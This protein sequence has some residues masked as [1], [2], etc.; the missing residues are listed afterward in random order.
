MTISTNQSISAHA[1]VEV[2]ANQVKNSDDAKAHCQNKGMALCSYEEICPNGENTVP[3]GGYVTGTYNYGHYSYHAGKGG[4]YGKIQAIAVEGDT[5]TGF[6][7]VGEGVAVE[8]R[9]MDPCKK[10][11]NE[12]CAPGF[13][14]CG[15]SKHCDI[16]GDCGM[17][18]CCSEKANEINH[19][20]GGPAFDYRFQCSYTTSDEF[21]S[22]DTNAN[23]YPWMLNVACCPDTAGGG[24]DPHFYGF[25]G[26]FFTWQGHCDVILVKTPKFSNTDSNLEAHIRTKKVRKWSA[27]D[28][29][30]M[31]V[32]QDTIEIRSTDGN[33]VLNGSKVESVRNASFTVVKSAS[34]SEKRVVL[35]DFVFDEDK[36]FQVKVNTRSKMIYATLSGK[37]P[38]GTEGILGSPHSPGLFTRNG[39]SMTNKDVNEFVE[40]W[41]VRDND[42]QLFQ[43]IRFPQFP[44]KCLYHMSELQSHIHSRRLQEVGTIT[45]EEASDACATHHP[46][47]LHDFCIEDVFST[48]DLDSAKDAF[49]G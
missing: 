3:T 8:G 19:C 28:S 45:E 15:G 7:Q 33:L 26:T 34:A 23:N 41:Q 1:Q 9:R 31:K 43:Q 48:M 46:G 38:E 30:A 10:L 17:D 6:V 39:R 40:T 27:I 4:E 21:E 2:E 29:I 37:Y 12:V 11:A 35:Y 36:I 18:Q 42:P 49:Y 20:G 32:G 14:D 47:P 22:W 16:N 44:T 25:G 13:N 24:G 5:Y